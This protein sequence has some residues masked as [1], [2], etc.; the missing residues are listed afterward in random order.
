[1][2]QE[3]TFHNTPLSSNSLA[4]KGTYVDLYTRCLGKG[5]NNRN[6]EYF[7]HTCGRGKKQRYQINQFAYLR[8]NDCGYFVQLKDFRWNC[9][10][11]STIYYPTDYCRCLKRAFC[12]FKHNKKSIDDC[13]EHHFCDSL[14][15]MPMED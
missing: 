13:W 7:Y 4:Y 6:E 12:I 1:M 11:H 8:C 15:E 5:C 10:K 3:I 14:L 9:S 2:N